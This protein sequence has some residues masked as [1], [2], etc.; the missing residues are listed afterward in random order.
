MKAYKTNI[1]EETLNNEYYRKVLST[2]KQ[3]QL[4]VMSLKP[5]E[6]IPEEVHEGTN[7]FIR[8]ESGEARVIVEG[9]EFSLKDNDIII[10]PTGKKHYV[11]NTSEEKD[12][13]LYSIYAPPEHPEGTIHKTKEEA[14]SAEHSH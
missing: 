13:K 11:K 9:E 8:I 5:E 4:V 3:M 6:D 1:E 10:I 2:E 7:Q 12:L 14:D